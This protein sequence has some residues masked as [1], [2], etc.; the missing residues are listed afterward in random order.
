MSRAY[1]SSVRVL[2]VVIVP[3]V[4]AVACLAWSATRPPE[5]P[6]AGVGLSAPAPEPPPRTV[7][8]EATLAVE[9]APVLIVAERPGARAAK[10]ARTCL[11]YPM[12]ASGDEKVRIC[13]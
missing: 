11:D 3:A 10:K 6:L 8:G 5:V 7:V 4:L 2:S 1:D 12:Y 13:E 9:L